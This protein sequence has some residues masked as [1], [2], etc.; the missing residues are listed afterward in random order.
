VMNMIFISML[1]G[2][3]VLISSNWRAIGQ[4]LVAF[5]TA[6]FFVIAF[7][8]I[9]VR[10]QNARKEV[11]RLADQLSEANHQLREYAA[12]V[13]ELAGSQERNRLAREIHDGLGHYLTA[14]NMQIRAA[15]AVM[16]Q[17]P[18]QAQEA[19][20]KAEALA[21]ESLADVRRSVA[22]LRSTPTLSRP[23]PEALEALVGEIVAAGLVGEFHLLGQPRQL[24]TQ[25]ELTIF[26][27][28][29]E[30]LTNIHKHALASKIDLTLEFAQEWVRLIITDNGVG[31]MKD[32]GEGSAVTGGFGLLGVRE[33][34]HLLGG[35]M[36]IRTAPNQGFCMEIEIAE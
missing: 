35:R 12:R 17:N 14:L 20:D 32:S 26:R 34:V 16:Q 7:T 23:L 13:E 11:E 10:E 21:Q 24:S 15:S 9:L 28:A 36:S 8:Q 19:L 30:G 29:Q 2:N 3:V 5:Q 1:L 22:A 25:A 31:S 4:G 6:F 27:A 33:R 18:A